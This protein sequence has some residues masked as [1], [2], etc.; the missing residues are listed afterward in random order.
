MNSP[1]MSELIRGRMVI[2][3]KLFSDLLETHEHGGNNRGEVVETLL[4]KQGGRPGD[5][6]CMAFVATLYEFACKSY[7]VK[8]DIDLNLSCS[9]AAQRAKELGR[10]HEDKS[11]ARPGDLV[12]IPGGPTGYKHVEIVTDPVNEHGVIATIGGN[13]NEAGSAE[14]DGVN[15]EKR[16]GKLAFIVL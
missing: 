12:L 11:L 8:P 9:Q 3:A 15:R 10:Y 14:G 6:W 7:G 16:G 5:P 1:S 13:T 2:Y 4:R